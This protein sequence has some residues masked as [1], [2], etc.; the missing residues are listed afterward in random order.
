MQGCRGCT[1][2]VLLLPSDDGSLFV[3]PTPSSPKRSI[4]C[5]R[6]EH[7]PGWLLLQAHYHFEH[8]QKSVQADLARQLVNL[9]E[10][11]RARVI[12]LSFTRGRA[13]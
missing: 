11:C 13:V 5:G 10:Q 9:L 6:S 1:E 4:H 2:E 3:R 8:A 12:D 7:T